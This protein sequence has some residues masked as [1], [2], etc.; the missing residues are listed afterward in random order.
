VGEFLEGV[1]QVSVL[2]FVVTCMAAAGLGLGVRDVVAPLRR[3]RLV[4]L[5]LAA[6]FVV[7]PAIALGLTEAIPLERSHAVGLL[8][9]AGAAGA[10]FLPKLAEAAKGDLAFS[11]GLMLLLMVVSVAFMPV[12]LP[13]LIPGLSAEPW[14]L[15]RPLLFTMLLPLAAGMAAKSASEQWAARV[16]P[17][18]VVVSNASMVL[19]LVLLIGLNF[20]AM[21]GTFGSGA[22]AVAVVFVALS[23]AVGYALGG[24][25]PGTRSVLGLGTGQRNV[26]AAL[27]I[28]TQNYPDDPGVVVMLLVSTLA[29][30]VVLLFCARVFARLSA[31]APGPSPD[32]SERA[33]HGSAQAGV[34]PAEVKR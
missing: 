9:L 30:L 6:N 26:A 5:A 34:T 17:L 15:L 19:T 7:A 33:P 18:F 8:L 22:V 14:P 32:D 11:V 12:A 28:A 10:P 3:A 16:R 29:G 25:V 31:A 2:A 23:L 21:L 1:S 13:R 24:P 20:R 4:A 27:I